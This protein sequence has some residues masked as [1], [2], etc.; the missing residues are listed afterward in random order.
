MSGRLAW[1]TIRPTREACVQE[2]ERTNP[3]VEGFPAPLRAMP[4]FIGLD[5]NTQL[6]MPLD[7]ER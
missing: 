5:L 3:A 7:E 1:G 6:H 4:V 2:I